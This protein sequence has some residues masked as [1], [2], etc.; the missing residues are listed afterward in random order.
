MKLRFL[1][2]SLLLCAWLPMVCH[3]EFKVTDQQ[4]L[5]VDQGEVSK[6]IDL[7]PKSYDQ[8]KGLYVEDKVY[9][10]DDY[11]LI[12]RGYR[13]LK[14]TGRTA[15]ADRIEV[16]SPD[17]TQVFAITENPHWFVGT[18]FIF[19]KE[20]VVIIDDAVPFVV[21]RKGVRPLEGLHAVAV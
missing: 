21:Y 15:G 4:V 16:Y 7:S 11:V 9:H 6:R 5:F 1:L 14:V 17:G 19:A 20:W 8:K 2:P 12:Y 13:H 18:Q 3:A 10:N